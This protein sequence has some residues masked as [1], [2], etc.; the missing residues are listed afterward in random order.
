MKF[1]TK[2]YGGVNKML[3][4][5]STSARAFLADVNDTADFRERTEIQFVVALQMLFEMP[6]QR[7]E[8]LQ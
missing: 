8:H 3:K 5:F 7:G 1:L 6:C 4:T 2:F